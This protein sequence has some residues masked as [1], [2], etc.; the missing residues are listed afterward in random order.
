[1]RS[2]TNPAR[3]T[4]R[5]R[6]KPTL[7]TSDLGDCAASLRASIGL[8]QTIAPIVDHHLL[9]FEVARAAARSGA[10]LHGRGAELAL[11]AVPTP[12]GDPDPTG[13]ATSHFTWIAKPTDIRAEVAALSGG[14]LRVVHQRI[15][16]PVCLEM[17][18]ALMALA[19][20]ERLQLFVTHRLG[21][22]AAPDAERLADLL[23]EQLTA[24]ESCAARA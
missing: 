16:S 8:R 2:I 1:M 6:L 20:P 10:V 15:Y 18:A 13:F 17:G 5:N 19:W 24:P 22:L 9:D 4:R 7:L 14:R 12:G 21:A 23:V 3:W 11:A